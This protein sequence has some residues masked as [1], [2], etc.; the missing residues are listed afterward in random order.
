MADTI[1][2]NTPGLQDDS[3][4]AGFVAAIIIVMVVVL[5]ALFF[6]QN[7]YFRATPDDT[8]NIEVTLPK[9]VTPDPTPAPTPVVP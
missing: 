7:G 8:T 1:I 5:G 4:S 2:T 3:G 6:Y 9:P